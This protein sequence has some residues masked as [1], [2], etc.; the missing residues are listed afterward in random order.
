MGTGVAR[1][2]AQ[3]VRLYCFYTV[4]YQEL[5]DR[6]LGPSAAYEYELITR[7]DPDAHVVEYKQ[8]GWLSVTRRKVD[9]ILEA[10][11]DNAGHSFLFSDPD[12]QFLGPTRARLARALGRRDLLFVK[13]SPGAHR[14]GTGFFLCRSNPKTLEFWRAVREMMEQDELCGDGDQDCVRKLLVGSLIEKIHRR[15]DH[16]GRSQLAAAGLSRRGVNP[17]GL[18]WGY[19]PVTFFGGGT[20]TGRRWEPGMTLPVPDRVVLHHANWTGNFANKAA[21]LRYVKEVVDIR[22]Q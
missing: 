17:Y 1:A 8:E 16:A 4:A 14:I 6:W 15:L 11:G 9:F 21:Q 5:I 18:R 19:L 12:V 2:P 7:C 10:L 13:D 3:P 22:A 20:L